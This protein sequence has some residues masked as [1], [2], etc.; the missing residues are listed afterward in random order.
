MVKSWGTPPIVQR[1]LQK[2]FL[3]KADLE[4]L[5]WDFQDVRGC[6][7]DL[8]LESILLFAKGQLSS[9]PF[10]SLSLY[11]SLSP[12]VSTGNSIQEPSCR[13]GGV[14]WFSSFPSHSL[15]APASIGEANIFTP[16]FYP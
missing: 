5:H 16:W 8:F 10:L 2:A 14:N 1:Y 12:P 7:K 13:G 15:F 11:L 9:F 3:G 6:P 4:D